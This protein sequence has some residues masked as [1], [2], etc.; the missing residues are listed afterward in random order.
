MAQYT[1]Q[2]PDGHTI[3]LEGPEGA[4]QADVI[5]QAQ[6]LYQPKAEIASTQFGETGGGAAVG[7]P[8][9]IDRTNVQPEPRPLESAL[10][11]ATKSFID[12]LVGAAQLA[13]GGGA[14]TSELAQRL[15][16]EATQYQEANPTAYGAGR[17]GRISVL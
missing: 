10:A 8:Q 14:G 7:R 17:I 15:S 13:T 9:G 3:T 1:V 16:Q 12:P 2:A 5:A 4:S 6:K 11:G